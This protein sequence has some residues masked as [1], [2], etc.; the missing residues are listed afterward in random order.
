MIGKKRLQIAVLLTCHNRKEKTE[1]CLEGL[2]GQRGIDA[3][4]LRFFL[5]D[6]GST[7]GTSD[8]VSFAYPQVHIIPGDGTL[9]WAGG[10]RLA[11]NSA[12]DY[13]SFD[14]FW[15]VNDDTIV[16][17]DTLKDLLTADEYAQKTYGKKGLY[18]SSTRDAVTKQFTYGGHRLISQNDYV[19]NDVVPNGS[20]QPCDLCNANILLVASDVYESV[21]ILSDRYTHALAD[22]DYSLR[23]KRSGFPVLILPDYGGECSWDQKQ[24]SS[25]SRKN[26]MARIEYMNSP[27]GF[28]YKEF[29]FFTK[30]FFPGVYRRTWLTFWMK[31][32]FPRLWAWYK[33]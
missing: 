15:L 18:V 10:M 23:A 3:V 28:A 21:G 24:H 7:D 12:L 30:T 29:L 26:M 19:H 9:F 1:K 8:M 4:D 27:K 33:V 25:V 32:L 13:G 31:T 14:Y 17:P 2:H 11:W 6:D 22:Y 16:Y 5:V 20:F